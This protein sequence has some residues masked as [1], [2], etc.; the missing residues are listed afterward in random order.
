MLAIIGKGGEDGRAALQ[1]VLKGSNA[2]KKEQ[3]PLPGSPARSGCGRA[4]GHSPR[5]GRRRQPQVR[6]AAMKALRDQGTTNAIS[7][8]LACLH[9]G[10]DDAEARL[11]IPEAIQGIK[12][13][14]ADK[15][16]GSFLSDMA[17]DEAAK[18]ADAEKR[19]AR[20]DDADI[21]ALITVLDDFG[22][23]ETERET[24]KRC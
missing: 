19:Q 8:L 13:R 21:Q 24:A 17:S 5:I 14:E 16:L 7:A 18:R 3:G 15:R 12:K 11:F 2:E 6:R 23:P 10:E 1:N 20:F 9:S 4:G 22:R